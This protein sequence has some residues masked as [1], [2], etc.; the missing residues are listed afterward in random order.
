M[1]TYRSP[2]GT[3]G[4]IGFCGSVAV[5]AATLP[6]DQNKFKNSP[7][8]SILRAF[9]S[10]AWQPHCHA[11]TESDRPDRSQWGTI[12]I[13]RSRLK[14]LIS[15]IKYDFSDF[16]PRSPLFQKTQIYRPAV[17]IVPEL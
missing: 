14:K 9:P 1:D 15:L 12:G 16:R 7:I 10:E 3:I 8:P 2:L 13:D 6:D 5:P 4:C 17:L 11:A